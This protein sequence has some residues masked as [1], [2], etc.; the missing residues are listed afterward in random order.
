MKIICGM[1][2]HEANTFSS[3]RGTLTRFLP[4]GS[5]VT[6]EAVFPR[7]KDAF[8]Y[9]GGMIEAAAKHNAELIPTVAFQGV[10]P[11]LTK[12]CFK[13]VFDALMERIEKHISE[14]DGICL[15]LH[16]AGVAEDIMDMEAY[17]LREVRKLAGN[18]MPITV[19]LDLHGNISDEM[20]RYSNGLFGIKEYPHI[21]EREAGK[22]AMESLIRMLEKGEKLSTAVT[23]MNM[24][25]PCGVGM[26]TKTPMSMFTNYVKEYARK[27]KLVDA[28]LFHG[29]PYA[30]VPFSSASIVAV[31]DQD[32]LKEA[33]QATEELADYV[34]ENREKLN[35]VYPQPK[36]AI[37]QALK[38]TENKK[39][40]IINEASDNVGGGCPG[41][42]TYLLRALLEANPPKSIFGYIHDEKLAV[43]AHA[44]GVGGR[45]SGFL[46]AHTDD[47]HGNPIEIYD[48]EVCCL[49]DG[50]A[51]YETPVMYHMDVNYGKTARLKIGN[52]EVI[53]TEK[54]PEQT[55][56]DRPFIVGGTDFM[57][58]DLVCL[59]STN[60]FRAFFGEKVGSI[61]TTDP[62]GI[63]T[64]NLRQ[65]NFKNIQRPIWPLDQM[66][67]RK[68]E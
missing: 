43:A 21:D 12:E 38:L 52:V 48:A 28:T 66:A 68:G 32:S 42:G 4:E 25:I 11:V 13:T 37:E 51:V 20:V 59:K 31:C 17:I 57:G 47:L 53:V 46:G 45:V 23:R 30:D 65:L 50:K 56:D 18:E 44:A 3:E 2:G 55:F 10:G 1:L 64:G 33:K 60:H 7:H 22:L 9:I 8:S 5:W 6:D 15:A 35:I 27:Y 54:V 26:T 40:V 29:F 63:Q 67:N 16:G 58:Y 14:S 41:D 62:P 49:S 24:L 39:P 19:C 61:I 34:W 36:E